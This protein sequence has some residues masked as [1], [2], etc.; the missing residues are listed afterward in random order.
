MSAKK[1][2]ISGKPTKNAAP[3]NA[4]EWVGRQEKPEAVAG[5]VKRLTIDIPEELHNAIKSQCAMRGAKISD[6]L[7]AMLMQKYGNK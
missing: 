7:R 4:D 6:E 5:K 1:V 2:S 3:A